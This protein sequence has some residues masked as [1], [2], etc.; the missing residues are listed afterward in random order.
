MT[1]E[2]SADVLARIRALV[3]ARSGL[4]FRD[5]R[6]AQFAATVAAATQATLTPDLLSYFALIRENAKVFDDLVS[7]LVVGETY[8]FREPHK[9]EHLRT[10][11]FPELLTGRDP[12]RAL[13]AWSA[14]CSTGEEAYSLAMLFDEAGL[15]S[16]RVLGTD[17]SRRSL[18]RAERGRYR[19]WS[20][21]G[22]EDRYLDRYFSALENDHVVV[23]P[24]KERV[25]FAHL[26]LMSGD[27]PSFTN[28]TA[29]VDVIF[30]RNVLI[31]F[32]RETVQRIGRRLLSCLSE[33]G[34]LVTGSCDPEIQVESG[35]ELV[36][37][38]SGA[39]YR[40][41]TAR[42]RPSLVRHSPP[43]RKAT[44]SGIRAAFTAEPVQ[45]SNGAPSHSPSEESAR[46]ADEVR[47]LSQRSQLVDAMTA[48]ER[49]VS[50]DPFSSELQY[51]HAS[52]LLQLGN[53]DAAER[54]ARRA[55]YLD[56][57][58]AVG[59]FLVGVILQRRN[60]REAST[61]AFRTA[62]EIA[63]SRPREEALRF[64]DGQVTGAL[65]DAAYAQ[66]YTVKAASR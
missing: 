61:R 32:D 20:L 50:A 66:L 14:G 7:E 38:R 31:Y 23:E 54:A 53:L 60:D 42:A 34:I 51:L 43:L 19:R 11:V 6:H 44:S 15:P 37:T 2:E 22:V 21:R 40:R 25:C 63:S 18:A 24:I 3:A 29:D 47:L 9:L 30:C 45:W 10:T 35:F 65:S 33:G 13:Q 56:R 4:V 48:C 16:A 28:R 12:T 41:E 64:G 5:A 57:S 26:N 1:A 49:F 46:R 58:L 36:M 52:L 17:L 59:H 55:V 8:F 27:Y 39:F 62:Y